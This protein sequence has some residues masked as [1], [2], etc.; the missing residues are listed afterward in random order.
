MEKLTSLKEE[1]VVLPN[2]HLS[3][4]EGLWQQETKAE[5][6]METM[7]CSPSTMGTILA[8]LATQIW[9]RRGLEM[10]DLKAIKTWI[11]TKTSSKRKKMKMEL[12]MTVMEKMKTSRLMKHKTWWRMKMPT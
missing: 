6:E 2:C 1:E 5:M 4:E 9:D 10:S 12:M 11:S 8:F 7:T 3:E